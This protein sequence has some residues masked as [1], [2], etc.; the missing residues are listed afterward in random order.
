LTREYHLTNFHPQ[1][2]LSVY[3]GN[4]PEVKEPEN[5]RVAPVISGD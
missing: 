4:I 1:R 3:F 5:K 2:D